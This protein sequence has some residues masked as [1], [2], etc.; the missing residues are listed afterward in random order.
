MISTPPFQRHALAAG[1]F[2]ALLAV[3]PAMAAS[4]GSFC[5]GAVTPGEPNDLAHVAGDQTLEYAVEQPA[6]MVTCG[7]GYMLEKCG[8]H[9]N[10]LK[11]FDKCIAAGYPGAMIWKAL[12]LEE[13]AGIAQDSVQA[14]ELLHRAAL[15]DDPAYA[16]IGKMHYA[17]ALLLGRGVPKDEAAARQWFQAAAAQGSEE[18]REFLKTGYHT[19]HRELN[20]MGAGTPTA[21]ALAGPPTG[22]NASLPRPQ[23]AAGAAGKVTTA[24]RLAD[25][26]TNPP[27]APAPLTTPL[28]SPQPLASPAPTETDIQGQRLEHRA[29]LPPPAVPVASLGVGLLLFASFAAG[30]L[31]QRRRA[32]SGQVCLSFR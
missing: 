3:N 7:K 20:G 31:R 18:A 32:R 13:G 21:A 11:V 15:S 9:E 10:A 27:P 5:G 24:I 2:L 16:A 28:I 19:G 4:P 6:S 30:I 29:A 23:P 17:T 22:D 25:A 1:L 14:A 12:L 26:A 8:D